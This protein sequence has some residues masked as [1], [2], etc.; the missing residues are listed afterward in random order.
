[1]PRDAVWSPWD[2]QGFV[3]S[4]SWRMNY[5]RACAQA[6]S[7]TPAEAAAGVAA[8]VERMSWNSARDGSGGLASI[9][10]AYERPESLQAVQARTRRPLPIAGA[11]PPS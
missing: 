7:P 10:S 4:T 5:W 8:G 11:D 1:M 6:S 9:P 3:L 2:W